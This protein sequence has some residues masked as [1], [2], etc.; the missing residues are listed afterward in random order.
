M[1]LFLNRTGD[2]KVHEH[3]WGKMGHDQIGSI[4]KAKRTCGDW[5]EQKHDK[6]SDMACGTTG[7]ISEHHTHPTHD[8]ERTSA[9]EVGEQER[10]TENATT[11][12]V[13]YWKGEM[14]AKASRKNTLF[15]Q[16]LF[17]IVVFHLQ[18]EFF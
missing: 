11:S 14:K 15:F 12:I 16:T 13:E 4:L 18:N 10:K 1:A 7:V 6:T 9:A 8:Q 17:L 3:E 5:G 2:H